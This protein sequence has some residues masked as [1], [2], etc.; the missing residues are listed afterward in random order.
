MLHVKC[1]DVMSGEKCQEHNDLYR[2]GH[3]DA[4]KNLFITGFPVTPYNGLFLSMND[5]PSITSST[6]CSRVL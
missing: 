5:T 2:V 1:L 6:F 3:G 4:A